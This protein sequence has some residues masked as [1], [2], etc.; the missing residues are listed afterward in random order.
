MTGRAVE[1]LYMLIPLS[2]VLV[3]LVAVLFWWAAHA[4]QFDDLE[5]PA[6]RILLDDDTSSG[7]RP[8]KPVRGPGVD[9]GQE[10]TRRAP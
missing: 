9:L 5:G 7:A 1:I 2:V 10:G 3:L 6:R 4:G 8:P